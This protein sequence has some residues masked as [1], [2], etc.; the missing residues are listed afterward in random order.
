M[1]ALSTL[2]LTVYNT[3]VDYWPDK[4]VSFTGLL[5]AVVMVV[6]LWKMFEKAGEEGWKAIVP[7][8]N[9]YTMFRLAGRNGW[10]FLL[11]FIP[12]VNIIVYVIVMLDFGKHFG[13]SSVW[14]FFLLVLLPFIG[15]LLLGFGS[16]KYVGPKHA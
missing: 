1:D 16:D 7:F 2:A 3:G 4:S 12:F 15:Y 8:Y 9:T 10:G 14:S 6:A 5:L 11:G 13:K